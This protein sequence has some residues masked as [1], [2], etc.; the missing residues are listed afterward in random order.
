MMLTDDPFERDDLMMAFSGYA[1]E[2][3]KA[4]EDLMAM[5]LSKVEKDFMDAQGKRSNIA[6]PIQKQV[7]ALIQENQF[8]EANKVLLNEAVPA[9]NHVLDI[10]AQFHQYQ[11]SQGQQAIAKAQSIYAVGRYRI[12]LLSSGLVIV[13]TLITGYML[14][15]MWS[16]HGY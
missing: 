3:I 12:F 9:Q 7:V 2:F 8:K 13:A 11:Q 14:R 6:V 15:K 16:T 5:N 10:L 4:R 1:G